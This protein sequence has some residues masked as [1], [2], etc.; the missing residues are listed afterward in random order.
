MKAIV[1]GRLI[2]PDAEGELHVV[3]Q[4]A[5]LYDNKINRIVP[6]EEL[7]V[8]CGA[9]LEE[10]F[11]AEDNYVSPG[12]INV[13]IHGC[14]G[15]DVM[16]EDDGRALTEISRF[17]AETGVTAWLPTTMTYDLP[18]VYGAL[19]RIREFI[20]MEKDGAVVLGAHLEGPFISPAKRGAQKV[21]HIIPADFSL[22]QEYA[23]VLKLITLAPE[24]LRGDYRFAEQC[25]AEGIVLSLGHSNADYHTAR[26]AIEEHGMK[27]VTHL[28]N[29]M[30]GLH[31]RE[32]GLVGAA[33]STEADCELIADNVHVHPMLQRLVWQAK[34]GRHIILI[35][36]SMRACGL[37]DGESELGGQKVF[38]KGQKALLA[39]GTIA[40]SVLTMD[41]AVAN[42][43]ANT[44]ADMAQAVACVT[45]TPARGLGI[46]EDYGSLEPGKRADITVFDEG[47]RVKATFVG[48][49]RVY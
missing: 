33:L 44:G 43:R 8:Q 38:V 39:D 41:R 9:L 4:Q 6:E 28:F 13:H 48:G 32:P 10:V 2:V 37:E 18:R 26:E 34:Q 46:F 20:G 23:D 49:R 42:F 21:E 30:N 11:D 36:D 15:Y 14:M 7:Q 12:F 24:E 1:N 17:Q 29:A 16:D 22:V 35:T 31:H 5:L 25:I 47:V 40:G 3:R 19:S 45:C 27:H